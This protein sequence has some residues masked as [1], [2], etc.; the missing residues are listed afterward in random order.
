MTAAVSEMYNSMYNELMVFSSFIFSK[1]SF[2]WNTLQHYLISSMNGYCITTIKPNT[3]TS[4][5][6][7]NIPPNS[8]NIETNQDKYH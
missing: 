3:L 5:S 4:S 6:S 1:S 2:T 7:E 8:H